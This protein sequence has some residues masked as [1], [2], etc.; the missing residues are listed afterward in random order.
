[1][2]LKMA[3]R[4]QSISS[5]ALNHMALDSE[6]ETD[7]DTD[8]DAAIPNSSHTHNHTHSRTKVRHTSSIDSELTLTEINKLRLQDLDSS[9]GE[10]DVGGATGS[11]GF[12]TESGTLKRRSKKK[13]ASS[14]GS[15]AHAQNNQQPISD[16]NLVKSD[17]MQNKVLDTN[18]TQEGDTVVSGALGDSSLK[19]VGTAQELESDKNSQFPLMEGSDQSEARKTEA[20]VLA[21]ISE[22]E[23]VSSVPSSSGTGSGNH[24]GHVNGLVSTTTS[25]DGYDS[26]SSIN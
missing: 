1:M 6:E 18:S 24:V 17:A 5:M 3:K 15:N 10:G 2:Q 8:L 23:S 20:A 13:R 7:E 22:A 26:T 25:N 4:L 19:P 21:G 9:E 14:T 12:E 11:N 16:K